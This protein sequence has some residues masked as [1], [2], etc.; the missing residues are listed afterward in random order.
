MGARYQKENDDRE[1]GV[2]PLLFFCDHDLPASH[3]HGGEQGTGTNQPYVARL[4]QSSLSFAPPP[5]PQ[6]AALLDLLAHVK[7]TPEFFSS[8]Q[9]VKVVSVF[10][11]RFHAMGVL[12]AIVQCRHRTRA[13]ASRGPHH[14]LEIDRA[15]S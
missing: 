2:C 13:L 3:H 1:V 15:T 11:L 8:K 4:V 14:H 6:S 7:V 5:S 10:Y 9:K 12:P